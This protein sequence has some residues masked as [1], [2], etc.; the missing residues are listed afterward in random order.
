[1][2]KRIFISFAMEDKQFRDFLVGQSRNEASP[3]EFIDM[4]AKEAWDNSWKTN[5][6]AR[7]KGCDGLIALLSSNTSQADGALWEIECAKEENIPILGILINKFDTYTPPQM[8]GEKVVTWSWNNIKEF[9]N[10]L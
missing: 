5:C 8:L 7:I 6:R 4:S 10:N 2:N 3:F 9:I 1:M